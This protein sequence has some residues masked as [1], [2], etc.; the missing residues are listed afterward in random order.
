ME[1]IMNTRIIALALCALFLNTAAF[2]QSS[3]TYQVPRTEHGQPDFQGVWGT[4]FSTMLERPPGLPPALPAEAAAGFAQAVAQVGEGTNTDPDIE[5][6]GAPVLAVVNGEHRTSVIV[7]P[8][9]GQL[10]YNEVGLQRSSHNYFEGIGYDGPEQRPGVERCIEAWASPPM[11]AFMY[12]LYNGIVQTPDTIAIISEEAAAQRFIYLN[13]ESRPDAL[14]SF[15]GHSIGHWEGDTLV[16][17]TTHYSDVNPERATVGRPMLLSSEARVT[18]RFTRTSDT[19]LNYK[20]R[21]ED[22]TYYT[23]AWDGEFSFTRNVENDH[24]YEYACHEGNY[25]MTGALR[26]ARYVESEAAK[27]ANN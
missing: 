10:P 8:E 11:R 22:P 1:F 12:Q 6:F 13:G 23:E 16:V 27:E 15:E 7:S 26:G 20:F 4:R 24:I 5:S 18:E 9:N 21:V 2:S 14:R 19:E 17:V 3:D 25:S